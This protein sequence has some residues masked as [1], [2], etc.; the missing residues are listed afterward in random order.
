MEDN[1]SFKS[2]LNEMVLR[3]Y[4]DVVLIVLKESPIDE[5]DIP[6]SCP[7]AFEQAMDNDFWPE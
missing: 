2:S 1:P 7:Y 4:D 5:S 3:A 6:A